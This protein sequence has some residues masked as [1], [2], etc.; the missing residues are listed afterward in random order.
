MNPWLVVTTR[1]HY[2]QRNPNQERGKEIARNGF[3][4]VIARTRIP[5]APGSMTQTRKEKGKVAILIN[6]RT[7][8]KDD[9][10][11]RPLSAEIE[12]KAKAEAEA[13]ADPAIGGV[14]LVLQL[15]LDRHQGESHRLVRRISYRASRS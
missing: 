2:Q 7:D 5:P 12:A 15:H 14:A 1:V 9:V 10:V 3:K 11:I 13:T 6:P 4:R 8:P